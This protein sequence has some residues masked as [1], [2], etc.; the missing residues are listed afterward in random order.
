MTDPHDIVRRGYDKIA[1]A[2]F[3]WALSFESPA[4]RWLERFLEQVPRGARVLDLGCG[5]GGTSTQALAER[6]E[7]LGIDISEAQIARARER[8]PGATFLRA[9]ATQVELDA[10]SFDGIVSLFMFG[11]VRRR[12][13]G[14]LLRRIHT[15]LR[16][17]G[18]FLCTLGTANA[19]DVVEDEWFGEPMFFASLDEEANATMLRHAGFDLVDARVVPFEEPGHGLVRFM[20]VLATTSGRATPDVR[21]VPA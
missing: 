4:R 15:W 10:A 9:D 12:A 5:G 16:P 19:A 8:V 14:P 20:W 1:D 11:H 17:G 6:Y 13:Q 21:P 3:E 2:Y 18:W 7:V